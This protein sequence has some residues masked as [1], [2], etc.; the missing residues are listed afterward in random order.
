[1]RAALPAAAVLLLAGCAVGS[2][3]G[4]HPP[5][6][7]THP[8]AQRT[9]P[10]IPAFH[11]DVDPDRVVTVSRCTADF[12]DVQGVLNKVQYV[13]RALGEPDALL[14]AYAA[15]DDPPSDPCPV[16]G[17]DAGDPLILWLALESGEIV[18]VRAPVDGCGAPQAHAVAAYDSTEFETIL[19]AREVAVSSP[20]PTP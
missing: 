7:I 10:D 3:T 13:Q 20:R 6:S 12:H 2:P 17:G 15:A 5:I 18:A 9:C 1:M 16:D 4:S 14:E 11:L 8:H 19:V